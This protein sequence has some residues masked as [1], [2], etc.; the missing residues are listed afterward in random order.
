MGAAAGR[1]LGL[2]AFIVYATW[3]AFQGDHLHLRSLPLAVLFAGAVR[4]S[5]HAWFGPKP[6]MVAGLLPFSP[7]LL[8]LWAPGRLPLHLL[9]LPR[10]L[11]QGVL[12][13]PARL[14]G[15]RAAQVL[16]RRALL[17]AD[18]PE[19]PSL[20]PVPRAAVPR[21]CWRTTSGK[22]FWFTDPAGVEHFG[23]GR[24]HA[25]ARR[26]TSSCSA[27]TP[28]A[29]TR[30]ATGRRRDR[31]ALADR[32]LR[33]SLTTASSCLNG[34]TCAGPG[35]ACSGWRSPTSTSGSARMGVWHD[36]R[37]F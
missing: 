10:R 19:H 8:I 11:L 30:C 15:R 13:R 36:W 20:F 31:P 26:S 7:A 17:P 16:P 28:S 33:R 24:R 2:S 12:G 25:R 6:G 27:A 29:A 37:I 35:A 21:A 14:R 1:F 22:A 9:L 34:G 5:P 3:A 4:R 32:R 18:P 23:I